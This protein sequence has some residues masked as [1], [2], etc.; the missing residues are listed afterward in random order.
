MSNKIDT[1]CVHGGSHRF[2]D[3][4]GSLTFPLYQT[5]A[6]SHTKLGHNE[7][8]F[9]YTRISNPTRQYLE[10]TVAALEKA[11]DCIGFA[12][13]MAA[14]S[15]CFE[16]LKQGDHVVCSADLYGGTVLYIDT[17]AKKNGLR[18]T[19]ADTTN[20]EALRDAME[21]GT[22]ALYIETPSNPMMNVTDIRSCGYKLSLYFV[23]RH[24]HAPTVS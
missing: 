23:F 7:H 10:E 16:L 2:P 24:R 11:E 9:D 15:A 17:I 8:G 4:T 22:K 1:L 19:Y 20:P 13:G 6:F 3:E 21:P 18:F 5:A 12:T 14:V